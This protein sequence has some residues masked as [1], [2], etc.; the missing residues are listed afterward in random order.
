MCIITVELISTFINP[1]SV[2]STFFDLSVHGILVDMTSNETVPVDSVPLATVSKG[3]IS[4]EAGCCP[5]LLG[6]TLRDD[7]AERLAATLKALA[8]PVRVRLIN[9]VAQA[10]EL[11]ACD[12][13]ELLDRSQP[14]VSH[15]LSILVKA[16]LLHREQRGKWAWFSLED[17][18]LAE[19]RSALGGV[20]S[21]RP[22]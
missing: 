20:A 3:S 1:T 19:V 7:E 18:R 8:D 5:H 15:H 4:D 12:L 13:P 22:V 17:Q 10:G 14:T 9:L 6:P 11:C 2:T 16:G 21:T